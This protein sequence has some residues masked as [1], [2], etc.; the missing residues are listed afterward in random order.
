MRLVP[1]LVVIHFMISPS[2]DDTL[3]FNATINA[4]S[5]APAARVHSFCSASSLPVLLAPPGPSPPGCCCCWLATI[6]ASEAAAPA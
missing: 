3:T 6:C 5:Q 1:Q 4:S 2:L